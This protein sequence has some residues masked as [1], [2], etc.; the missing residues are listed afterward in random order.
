[1]DTFVI[2]FETKTVNSWNYVAMYDNSH[3]TWLRHYNKIKDEISK[4]V[5]TIRNSNKAKMSQQVGTTHSTLTYTVTPHSLCAC[6]RG[7]TPSGHRCPIGHRC[8]GCISGD[9]QK[10][11]KTLT[12]V[13]CHI[14]HQ[15]TNYPKRIPLQPCSKQRH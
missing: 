12:K 10:H 14:R 8:S 2:L 5:L 13:V 1:M 3:A 15:G 4:R 7:Y 9:T 6:I 11:N